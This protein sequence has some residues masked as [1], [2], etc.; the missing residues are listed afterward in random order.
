M[1]RTLYFNCFVLGVD[2]SSMFLVKIAKSETVGTLK[3]AIKDKKP[4]CLNNIDPNKLTLYKVLIPNDNNLTQMLRTL[5]FDGGSDHIEE[6][7]AMSLV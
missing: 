2:M 4:Y 7:Q 5:L 6:L 3:D 1:S